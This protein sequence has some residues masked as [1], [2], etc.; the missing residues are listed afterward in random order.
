[1]NEIRHSEINVTCSPSIFHDNV[2][3]EQI[4]AS[5]TADSEEFFLSVANEE[6]Q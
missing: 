2:R 3:S 4:K 6:F 5:L 1:L